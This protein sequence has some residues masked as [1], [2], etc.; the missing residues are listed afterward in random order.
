MDDHIEIAFQ[1]SEGLGIPDVAFDQL[2]MGVRKRV[3]QIALLTPTLIEGIEIVEA[4]YTPALGQQPFA[5]M[6][7]NESG[8]AGKKNMPCHIELVAGHGD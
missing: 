1:M 4:G 6:T 7:A 2:E 3:S 8:G 5:Q